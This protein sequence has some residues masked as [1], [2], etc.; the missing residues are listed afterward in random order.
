MGRREERGESPPQPRAPVNPHRVRLVFLGAE[1]RLASSICPAPAGA[2]GAG[3][4]PPPSKRLRWEGATEETPWVIPTICRRSGERERAGKGASWQPVVR[5]TA[6]GK[7]FWSLSPTGCT[8][9][10][11]SPGTH[12]VPTSPAAAGRAG[13]RFSLS[14]RLAA[15][16][17]A[18]K[19]SWQGRA[20]MRQGSTL[21]GGAQLLCGCTPRPE[22]PSSSG[23]PPW[24]PRHFA[25]ALSP[26]LCQLA[27]RTA[28]R[29]PGL[30]TLA[31]RLL[32]KGHLLRTP[33]QL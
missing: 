15:P 6:P 22:E 5:K 10:G 26:A 25:A 19:Q 17:G 20:G 13:R 9:E 32:G 11:L 23:V 2:R 33:A 29:H 14:A 30:P 18:G 1:E 28:L 21:G 7:G 16:R 8:R 12:H 31:T 3:F 24:L 4:I 27:E